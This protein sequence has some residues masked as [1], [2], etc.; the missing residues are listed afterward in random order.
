ME[1]KTT[2]LDNMNQLYQW[3]TTWEKYVQKDTRERDSE[4][5]EVNTSSKKK[6]TRD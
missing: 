4:N 1:K 6:R 3:L 2:A 5:T